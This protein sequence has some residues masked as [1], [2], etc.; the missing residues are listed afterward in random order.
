MIFDAIWALLMLIA[1]SIVTDSA[2]KYVGME[3]YAAAAVINIIQQQ[4]MA[5][6]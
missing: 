6:S 4:L 3:S 5:L 1:A 2:R